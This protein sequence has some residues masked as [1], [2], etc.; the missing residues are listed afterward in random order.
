[1]ADY[2]S[3]IARAVSALPSKTDEDRRA[4]Y[5]RARKAL[6]ERLRALDPPLPETELAQQKCDLEAAIIRVE[7]QFL[8]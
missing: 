7:L 6:E 5:E 1:M 8:V 4:V 3:V 2:Y